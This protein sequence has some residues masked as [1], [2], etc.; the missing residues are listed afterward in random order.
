[1]FFA[2]EIFCKSKVVG[3]KNN[4]KTKQKSKKCPCSKDYWNSQT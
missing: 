4:R 2:L 1:M 3:K